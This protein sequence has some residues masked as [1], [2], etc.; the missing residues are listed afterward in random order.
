[1]LPILLNFNQFRA[2]RS[3]SLKSMKRVLILSQHLHNNYGGLLQAFALQ[4]VVKEL[5]FEVGIRFKY[6]LSRI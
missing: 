4:K 1:M 6:Q 5:G 2:N 3:L